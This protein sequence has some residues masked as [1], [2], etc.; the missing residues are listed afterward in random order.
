M[1]K[2][3]EVSPAAQRFVA[4]TREIAALLEKEFAAELS[5]T[6]ATNVW[7]VAPTSLWWDPRWMSIRIAALLAIAAL[8]AGLV[9][10]A[11]ELRDPKT[12]R[13]DSKIASAEQAVIMDLPR[14]SSL[15]AEA[16]GDS[17]KD[18]PYEAERAFVSTAKFPI[19]TVGLL[20]DTSSYERIQALINAG[21]RPHKEAVHIKNMINYFDY[22]YPMPS[23]DRPFS[24]N[25]EAATCPW[26]QNHWLVRVGIKCRDAETAVVARDVKIEIRFDVSSIESYRILGSDEGIERQNSSRAP[27]RTTLNHGQSV[28]TLYEVVRAAKRIARPGVHLMDVVASYKRPGKEQ[29]EVAQVPLTGFGGK[30][31][32]ASDDFRFAAAIAHF[33]VI[34]CGDVSA[35]ALN[36]VIDEAEQARAQASFKARTDF[37]QLA[38][39]ARELFF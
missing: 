29:L 15:E 16:F 13:R 19:A 7:P 35:D 25:V 34:L 21:K 11:V 26:N 18:L 27:A 31:E 38:K 1:E 20:V 10:W 32:D 14:D 9:I 24:I 3:I 28:T 37:V 33:G 8:I 4:E 23:D 36:T 2:L 12:V 6:T 17:V 22:A 39:K 30:F 5:S